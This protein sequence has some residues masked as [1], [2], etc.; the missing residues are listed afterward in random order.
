MG[1]G[2]DIYLDHDY[3][4]NIYTTWHTISFYVLSVNYF[5]DLLS[6]EKY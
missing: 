6:R 5:E 2:R 4:K 3:Q 1:G